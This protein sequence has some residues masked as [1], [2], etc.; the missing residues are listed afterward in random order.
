MKTKEYPIDSLQL[1]AA[2]TETVHAPELK[3]KGRYL[4][5]RELGRGG[6]G[7]VYLAKDLQLHGRPVVIKVLLDESGENPWLIKKFHQEVEALS[8]LDHPGIVQVI[9][10][11]ETPDGKPFL[12]MQFI[13]G[14]DLRSLLSPEGMDLEQVV[15]L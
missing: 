1:S 4:I 10:S 7:V 15:F 5:E 12:V 8:R 6:I 11:G 14:R 13:K 9:D 3:F 2:E